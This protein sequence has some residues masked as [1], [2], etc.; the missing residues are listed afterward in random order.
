MDSDTILILALVG[1]GF[2][3]YKQQNAQAQ[4]QQAIIN[5]KNSALGQLETGLVSD[6]SKGLGSFFS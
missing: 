4:S 3:I 2:Y 5:K 6:L 1:V